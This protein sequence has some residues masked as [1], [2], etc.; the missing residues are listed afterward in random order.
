MTTQPGALFGDHKD[1]HLPGIL[2]WA[3]G[4]ATHDPI[5]HLFWFEAP[6]QERHFHQIHGWLRAHAGRKRWVTMAGA[7]PGK[8][9][10]SISRRW[11]KLEITLVHEGPA[12]HTMKIAVF[13]LEATEEPKEQPAKPAPLFPAT[14]TAKPTTRR[15]T[16]H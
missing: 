3:T 16:R 5:G 12:I 1:E 13:R 15:T 4:R 2:T 11:A 8:T 9:H 7:T 14:E 6:M 10:W